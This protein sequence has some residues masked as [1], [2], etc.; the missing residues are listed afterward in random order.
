MEA[1]TL[2]GSEDEEWVFA[3]EKQKASHEAG[4]NASH[5]FFGPRIKICF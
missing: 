2:G 3:C 5:E 4:P 1:E